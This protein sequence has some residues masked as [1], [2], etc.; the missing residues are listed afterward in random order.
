MKVGDHVKVIK[1]FEHTYIKW[2]SAMDKSIGESGIITRKTK[3]KDSFLVHFPKT[4]QD[5]CYIKKVLKPLLSLKDKLGLLKNL[6]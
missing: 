3:H 6:K 1:K 4:N 2:D 5:W